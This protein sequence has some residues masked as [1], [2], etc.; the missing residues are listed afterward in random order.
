MF[1][2]LIVPLDGSKL[3]EIAL[4]YAEEI[5]RHLGSEVILVNVRT[6]MEKLDKPEHREYLTKMAA[7]TEQNIK[8]SADKPVGEKVK[9]TSA[10]IGEPSL[11]QHPAEHIVNYAAKENASLIIMATHGRTGISHWALG[12]TAEKVARIFKCPVML[13]RASARPVKSVHFENIMVPLDG[14]I[15]GEA[16]LGYIENFASNLKTKI[17]VMNI[18]E[19]PYRFLAAPSPVGYYS[20]E[21]LIRVPYT[22]EELKPIKEA[23]DKYIRSVS[24]KLTAEKIANTFEVR[25]GSPGDEIVEA[26]GESHPDLLVM[27]SHG[28][29][30]FGRFDFGSVAEKVLHKGTAPILMVR[31]K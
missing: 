3:A 17:R 8:K 26:E 2:R 18:V 11:L 9:V 14:S 24:E 6:S 22:D 10:V 27:S 13:I 12:S 15:E 20:G 28:Q 29:S 31:P 19:M 23:A 25:I 1:K 4:P 16:S 30:G 7:L 21:G 5:A